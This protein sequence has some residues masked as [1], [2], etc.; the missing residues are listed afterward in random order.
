[1]SRAKVVRAVVIVDIYAFL[2]EMNDP[3]GMPD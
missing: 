1:M 3:A 2:V